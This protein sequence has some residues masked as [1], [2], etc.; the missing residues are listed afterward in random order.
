MLPELPDTTP[1][2]EAIG[3]LP[4]WPRGSVQVKQVVVANLPPGKAA[5]RKP[6]ILAARPVIL[7]LWSGRR[8]SNSRQPAW[9]A[10]TLPTELLPQ[11][12]IYFSP[13]FP[14]C[15][16]GV[17]ASESLLLPLLSCQFSHHGYS[18]YKERRDATCLIAAEANHTGE[19]DTKFKP[20]RGRGLKPTGTSVS[21]DRTHFLLI[22][23]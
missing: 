19:E 7:Y 5:C 20:V 23:L 6:F 10:G 3:P 14:A 12:R 17:P 4:S 8:D 16:K 1:E 18:S 13:K 11:N 9:K 21:P 15:Q 2:Y 22:T